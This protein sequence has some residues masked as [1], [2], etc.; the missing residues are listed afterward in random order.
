MRHL[1]LTSTFLVIVGFVFAQPDQKVDRGNVIEQRIEQ[2]AEAAEDENLDYTTL[3][4]QLAIYLDFPLNLNT[5]TVDELYGLG[6]LSNDQIL[7]FV[8]YREKYGQLFSLTELAFIEGWNQATA[9][10]ILPFVR[11]SLDEQKDKITF[12]KIKNYG[13]HEVVLRWQRILEDQAGY[14]DLSQE[15]LEENPNARYLGS[16]D[17]V[18]ARYRYRFGDRISFGMTAEKDNG[19]EF[20]QGSQP[21]GF[22]FYSGHVYLKDFGMIKQLAIGDYQAQFGQGLTFWSG[23]GFNRK[24]SFTLSTAQDGRG[25]TPYTSINENL[26][27]RG[28]GVTINQ[29]KFDFTAFYSGKR[30]DGNLADFETN[31]SLDFSD[32]EVLISSFQETGFHRTANEI[33]DKDAIFQEHFGGHVR[34]ATTNM[35]LGVTAAHMRL[36]GAINRNTDFYS[37][38]RFNGSEN[39]AIGANYFFRLSK[40]RIFGET[41]RS[42]NGGIATINGVNIE[43]N[44]RLLVNITQRHYDRNFQGVASVG[45]GEGTLIENESGIYFGVEFRPFKR[46]KLNAYIDQFR[47]PWLR[48]QTDAPSSGYDFF[49]QLEYQATSRT[50]IYF[51]YRDRLRQVNTRQD[52]EGVDFLVDNPRRNLRLNF[53]HSATRQI[54]LR[55]RI[56]LTEFGRG[57]EPISRGFMAYQDVIWSLKKVPIKIA[58]RYA[59]FDTDNFDSRIYAYENDVLYFFSIPAYSGRGTRAYILLKYDLGRNTDIWLRWAQTYFTDRQTVGSGLEEIDGNTRTEVKIQLRHRF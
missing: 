16:P 51:R 24:S 44:P 38:F 17:K 23:L 33:E 48:F 53:S 49:G 9:E 3:F 45:F 25:L 21:N 57:S 42:E 58:A 52:V 11:V 8:D 40:F 34:F 29:G 31:D 12:Y 28:G 30:I 7:Q 54:R 47:F 19:E 10:L 59:L 43:M 5:A 39:T 14:A 32:P 26:F 27:L 20:G 4:E 15:Q 35:R 55:S 18:F 2:L 36:N 1:V 46:W 13:K 22:D 41:A 56:E 6:L 37:Q 50:N